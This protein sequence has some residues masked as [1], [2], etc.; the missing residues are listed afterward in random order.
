MVVIKCDICKETFKPDVDKFEVSFEIKN[1]A[2]DFDFDF[3]ITCTIKL[4]KHF[5]IMDVD[6]NHFFKNKLKPLD[7][8]I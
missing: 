5:D 7:K 2:Y 3:C 4:L 8:Q 1:Y 6:N